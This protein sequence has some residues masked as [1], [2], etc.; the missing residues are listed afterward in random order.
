M[1]ESNRVI[2]NYFVILVFLAIDSL[3]NGMCNVLIPEVIYNNSLGTTVIGAIIGVQSIIGIF[4]LL[5]QATFIHK[6]GEMTCVKLGIF[7][8][9]IIYFLY[10]SGYVFFVYIGKFAE[11]FADRL[12]NS[13]ISKLVYDYTDNT[14]NRGKYRALVD[15]I[16]SLGAVIGPMLASYLL[17]NNY[18][19][20]FLIVSS[21]MLISLV[22]AFLIY[23]PSYIEKS[24]MINKKENDNKISKYY[25]S[26]ISKYYN[27]KNIVVLTIPTFLYSCFDIFESLLLSQ[28]LLKVH[29]FS[30]AELATLWTLLTALIII[31][32]Y[33]I[34]CLVDKNQMMLFVTAVIMIFSGGVLIFVCP[35]KVMLIIA[36]ALI[37]VGGLCYSSAFGVL[38][39]NM[40]TEENRLSES[41]VYRTIRLIGSALFSFSLAYLFDRNSEVTVFII[42]FL[43]LVASIITCMFYYKK[44]HMSAKSI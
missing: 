19:F 2:K 30:S 25:V 15:V 31:L 12:L 29:Q 22:V 35:T 36:V 33:P 41:E 26:H 44:L 11:G 27:N 38:F 6:F 18:T 4:I 1:K 32:Q 37:Y 3:G 39:G 16:S 17:I 43:I 42:V 5:P 40:T 10:S 14:N 9:A 28:Y 21:L 7:A 23:R 20:G 8:N 24:N 13:S 34:G